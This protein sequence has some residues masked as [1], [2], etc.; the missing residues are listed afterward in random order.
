MK[1]ILFLLKPG[2]YDGLGDPFYCPYCMIFEG[3]LKVYPQLTQEL[4]VRHV[5]FVKPRHQII[6]LI[7][8]ENQSCPVILFDKTP[9]FSLPFK[10][11]QY[12]NRFFL[13]EPEEIALYLSKVYKIPRAHF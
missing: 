4:E 8:E 7:G 3:V 11:H 1:P 10:V 5:D 12:G 2:F 9:S 6:E 13:N